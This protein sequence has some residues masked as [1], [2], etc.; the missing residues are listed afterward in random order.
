MSETQTKSGLTPD[1]ERIMDLLVSAWN[2]LMSLDR[3]IAPDDL[4]AFRDG[5]HQAQ[6]VLAL[7][8]LRRAFPEYW[9]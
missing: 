9:T 4:N 7:W 8:A 1:E 3:G 2:E 6:H 5:I